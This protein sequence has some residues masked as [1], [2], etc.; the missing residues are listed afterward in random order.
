MKY[1]IPGLISGFLVISFFASAQ[2]KYDVSKSDKEGKS[3]CF[4]EFMLG[5]INKSLVELLDYKNRVM[6]SKERVQY[7]ISIY[8]AEFSRKDYMNVFKDISTATASRDL[9]QT[10]EAGIIE[11][12]GALNKSIY[13][14]KTN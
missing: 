13:K 3:T 14:V 7:F 4:I 11:N 2:V 6:T 9:K 12:L 1:K 8:K 10:L 5:V